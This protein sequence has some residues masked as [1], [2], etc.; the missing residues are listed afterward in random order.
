MVLTILASP[1]IDPAF[2]FPYHTLCTLGRIVSAPRVRDLVR[3]LLLRDTVTH[4]PVA[5]LKRTLQDFPCFT[6]AVRGCLDDPACV[7]P[8]W[9]HDL[10][11]TWRLLRWREVARDRAD[12]AGIQASV[13]REASLYLLRELMREADALQSSIH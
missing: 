9:R 13:N 1:A 11:E 4:G 7:G 10:R 2:A 5:R 12:V 6:S 3:G 8:K